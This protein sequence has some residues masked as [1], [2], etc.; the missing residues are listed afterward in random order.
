MLSFCLNTKNF[1]ASNWGKKFYKFTCLPQGA[2]YSPRLFVRITAPILKYLRRRLITIILYIDDTLLLA[3]TIPEMHSNIETT[4][5]TFSQAG[6]LINTE[7]LHLTP[8][9]CIEFLGFVLNSEKFTI[10]L[11]NRKI[12]SLAELIRA[13]IKK[14]G[15][16]LTVRDLSKVI[17]K[18]VATFPCCEEATLHYRTLE[19]FK[20][21]ALHQSK[22]RW[23]TRDNFIKS[24]FAGTTMVD[25]THVSRHLY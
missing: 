5:S 10:S 17:G 9:T 13:T 12:H 4:M 24:M 8:T 22:N 7:K 3:E 15:N 23:A 18:I 6:F 19:R 16:N 1:C 2:M 20:V 25:A 14:S 21:K 11:S